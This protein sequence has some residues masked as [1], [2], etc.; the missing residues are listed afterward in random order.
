MLKRKN[1]TTSQTQGLRTKV[2]GPTCTCPD[3]FFFVSEMQTL[4]G[5]TA[6]APL[7]HKAAPAGLESAYRSAP[8][9]APNCVTRI[10]S[11]R[12]PQTF[13]ASRFA[14]RASSFE[15]RA[16]SCERRASALTCDVSSGV[17][18]EVLCCPFHGDGAGNL[19]VESPPV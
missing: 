10:N 11:D 9:Y 15:L 1:H 17:R 8:N 6:Q 14:L 18:H 5:R 19:Y 13:M 4:R 16:S 3:V 2:C 12:S 7:G